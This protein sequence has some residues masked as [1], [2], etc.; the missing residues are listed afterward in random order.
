MDR[1]IR[2]AALACLL[3]TAGLATGCTTES[4]ADSSSSSAA[5]DA[6]ASSERAGR[7]EA[8]ARADTKSSTAAAYRKWGLK[9]LAA[10]PAPPA[11]KP[12]RPTAEGGGVPVISEIPTQQ[13]IVFL[14]FDDGAEKDPK[15]VTMMRELKIPFTMFLT[16][17]AIRADYGYFKPLQHLGDGVQ[18]HTLTHPNL[19]TLGA[20]AQKREICGQQTKL[21]AEYG[22]TP[23]LLRPPYG[24]WNE[25]TRAA[26]ASCGLEAIVLWRESMQITNMQYQR[27]D[28]KL[29]PGDIIL[30]HFRGPSELKG[31]TMTEMTANLLRHIQEQGFAVARLEDYL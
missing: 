3:L 25:D 2:G 4:R 7:G 28:K 11:T 5:P 15:F 14:T 21:K 29:H 27:G 22:T 9:P 31:T 23:R 6:S 10:P 12:S 8:G 17:A 16:D 13:E 26:A 18:N 24:N 30:A 20:S 19:R 1:R